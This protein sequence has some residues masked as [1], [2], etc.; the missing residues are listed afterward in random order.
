M[1][2]L[3][4][5]SCSFAVLC[6]DSVVLCK[7]KMTFKLHRPRIVRVAFKKTGECLLLATSG[8]GTPGEIYSVSMGLMISYYRIY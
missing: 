2:F 1:N 5:A 7:E 6:L 8:D 4:S 3:V